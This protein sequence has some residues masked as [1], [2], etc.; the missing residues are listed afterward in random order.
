M[1]LAKKELKRLKFINQA[2]ITIQ[3]YLRRVILKRYEQ[4]EVI[5][6]I[7]KIQ[8][9]FRTYLKLHPV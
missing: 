7:E 6:K 1:F 9:A 8:R 2:A 4:P 3:R 5:S